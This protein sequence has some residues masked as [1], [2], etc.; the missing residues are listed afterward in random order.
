M[1]VYTVIKITTIII[2]FIKGRNID[3]RLSTKLKTSGKNGK[4]L[5]CMTGVFERGEAEPWDDY[6]HL[7]IHMKD[8]SNLMLQRYQL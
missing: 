7:E 8:L 3:A 1:T 4:S 5:P 2:P 6:T